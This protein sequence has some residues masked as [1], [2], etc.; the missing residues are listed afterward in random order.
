M[1]E[2]KRRVS[3]KYEWFYIEATKDNRKGGAK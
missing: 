1:E 2:A 3:N